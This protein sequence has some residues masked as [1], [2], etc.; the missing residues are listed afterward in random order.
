MN[1]PLKFYTPLLALFAL[2][3]VVI[4]FNFAVWGLHRHP[5]QPVW[6][7]ADA[8]PERGRALLRDRGCGACHVVPGVRGAVGMVGPKLDRVKERIYVAGVLP[9]TPEN[10]LF[11]IAH[12]KQA[13]PLTAMPDLGV[14]EA[15]A[16]DIAAYLYHLP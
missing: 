12:P 13:D 16:R 11:W 14:S 5:T 2:L 9:H 1:S 3:W 6:H 15:D 10:L 8:N 4:G 7:L